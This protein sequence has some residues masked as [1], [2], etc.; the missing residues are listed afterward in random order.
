VSLFTTSQNLGETMRYCPYMGIIRCSHNLCV[1]YDIR[2]FYLKYRKLS[3]VICYTPYSSIVTHSALNFSINIF[4]QPLFSI[5]SRQRRGINSY[6]VQ[7]L[8]LVF[9]HDMM[10][11]MNYRLYELLASLRKLFLTIIFYI[12]PLFSSLHPMAWCFV[13][14]K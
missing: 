5:T 13:I 7:P 10:P 2:I 9:S 6:T 8:Q 12:H 14:L 11:C 4:G 3:Y 1:L